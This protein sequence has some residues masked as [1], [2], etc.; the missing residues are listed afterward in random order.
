MR[1]EARRLNHQTPEAPSP[2]TRSCTIDADRSHC[3][4]CLRTIDEIASWRKMDNEARWAVLNAL[5]LRREDKAQT[6]RP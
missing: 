6:P 2:C 4:K 3:T 1:E 5:V